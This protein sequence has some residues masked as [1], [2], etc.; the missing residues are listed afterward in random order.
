MKID[1]TDSWPLSINV[2]LY[3]VIDR[4]L[5][6]NLY[7]SPETFLRSPETDDAEEEEDDDEALLALL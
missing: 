4:V 3:T 7:L 2:S 1:Q 6:F 5:T